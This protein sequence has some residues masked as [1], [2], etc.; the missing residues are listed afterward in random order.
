MIL[1][2]LGLCLFRRQ[3]SRN[4]CIRASAVGSRGVEPKSSISERVGS[5]FGSKSNTLHGEKTCDPP[6]PPPAITRYSST[7]SLRNSQPP[8]WEDCGAEASPS[9]DRRNSSSHEF[10]RRPASQ[11]MSNRSPVSVQTPAI[12]SISSTPSLADGFFYALSELKQPIQAPRPIVIIPAFLVPESPMEPQ[13]SHFSWS[14]NGTSQAPS[15][16]SVLTAQRI[17][18][19]ESELRCSWMSRNNRGTTDIPSVTITTRESQSGPP[20]TPA[21]FQQHPP[22]VEVGLGIGGR[23]IKSAEF[24]KK[25]HWSCEASRASNATFGPE[26][27][28]FMGT[29]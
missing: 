2:L 6:L 18:I 1:I 13:R 3:I 15:T 10:P 12:S 23:R 22:R 26:H 11:D 9:L 21:G 27:E 29:V 16:P 7:S 8:T 28:E 5:I 20:P 14:T 19:T 25:I 4:R 24:D 17:S